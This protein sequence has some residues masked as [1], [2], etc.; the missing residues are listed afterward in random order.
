M[1]LLLWLDDLRDPTKMDWS[2]WLSK[3]SPIDHPFKVV[4]V[5]S[6]AEFTGW[7]NANRLPDG[8]C[9]DHD[10]GAERFDERLY[11][12]A[13]TF[14]LIGE[15]HFGARVVQGLGDAPGDRMVVGDPHYEAAFAGH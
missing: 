13:E 10:L 9:F 3:Y 14:A 7:I 15:G 12:A 2:D 11:A 8:I 6:Y 5:K 1:K 4:W